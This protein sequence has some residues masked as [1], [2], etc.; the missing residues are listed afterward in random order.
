MLF[1]DYDDGTVS[2]IQTI[3]E[4]D[5]I[6][7][8]DQQEYPEYPDYQYAEPPVFKKWSIFLTNQFLH[9]YKKE[10]KTMLQ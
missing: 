1:R 3:P 8:A 5:P 6:N 9:I 10:K 2:V 7:L 4:D